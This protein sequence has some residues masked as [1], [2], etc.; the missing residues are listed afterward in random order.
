MSKKIKKVKHSPDP[1]KILPAVKPIHPHDGWIIKVDDDAETPIVVVPKFGQN[2]QN[3]KIMAASPAMY[4]TLND[5]LYWFKQAIKVGAIE[6]SQTN[7]DKIVALE[8]L[9]R[10]IAAQKTDFSNKEVT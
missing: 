1:W 3:V 8:H 6:N 4:E 9:L 10:R 2:E 5:V 7:D